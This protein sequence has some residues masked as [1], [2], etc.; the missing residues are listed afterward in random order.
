MYDPFLFLF[1]PILKKYEQLQELEF[2]FS[3]FRIAF[4]F[5]KILEK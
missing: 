5:T 4:W 3:K 2:K 1:E